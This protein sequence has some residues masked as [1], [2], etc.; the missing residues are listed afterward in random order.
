[1]EQ[2]PANLT[3]INRLPDEVLLEIFDLYRQSIINQYDYQWRKKYGWFNLAHVCRR[4][5]AAMFASTSRL[6]LNIVVG[7]EKPSHIKTILSGHLPILIDYSD[8]YGPSGI[9]TASA[10]WRMH[11]AL[12]HRNRV[13]EISF[14]GYG[15][16]FKKFIKATNYHFP[17]LESLVL[18]FPRFPRDHGEPDIPATFLR[19]PDRPDLPLRRLGLYDASLASVSGLLLSAT[20]LTDL[21]LSVNAADLGP[22]EAS[23]ILTCLQGAQCLRSLDL[24]A[25]YGFPDFRSQ[26]SIATPKDIVP[27]S[28]LTRFQ[29]Y[30]PTTFLNDLMSGLSAPSLQDV[31]F[32]LC[33]KSPLLYLSRVIDDVSEEFRSVSVTFEMDYFYLLSSTHPG[34]IDHSKPASFRL[35]V[36]YSP[37]SISSINS[38]PFTKL[39]MAEELTL[40]NLD[41]PSSNRTRWEHVFSLREFLRQFRSVR[42]LRVNPFV[43]N[44]GLYLKQDDGEAILPVLEQVELSITSRSNICSDEEYQ[45]RVAEALTAFEP[46]ERAGRLVKVYHC[47]QTQTQ[48]RNARC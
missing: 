6:D 36:N 17:A 33:K 28:K 26:D 9:I 31:C 30:G 14:G 35:N 7:P 1:V 10:L 20:A 43:Q 34:E 48:S 29:Y 44:V 25:P 15:V 16:T 42:V 41:F 46:C 27:I 32:V 2:S 40:N 5:H 8:P 4:W 13:R 11:A 23:L 19:G 24:S 12:R 22:S 39:A 37:Y 21:T 38:T 18:S 45:R 3:N 47:R